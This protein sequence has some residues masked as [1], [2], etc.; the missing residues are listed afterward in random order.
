MQPTVP[1]SGFHLPTL[2]IRTKMI[3]IG[4]VTL[5]SMA[6]IAGTY[7]WQFSQINTAI[8]AEL[9][10]AMR[11]DALHNV[12][13]RANALLENIR[14]FSLN[15]TDELD[16]IVQAQ[17]D[18]LSAAATQLTAE[19]AI[20]EALG[21]LQDGVARTE[22]A[23]LEIGYDGHPGSLAEL[24]QSASDIEAA[25]DAAIKAG[26]AIDK[27]ALAFLSLRGFDREYRLTRNE[28]VISSFDTALETFKAAPLYLPKAQKQEILGL[29]DTYVASFHE[30]V[31]S[32]NAVRAALVKLDSVIGAT[33]AALDDSR[34]QG[35]A[36]AH[37]AG[38]RVAELRDGLNTA[39]VGIICISTVLAL[40]LTTAIGSTITT[41]IRRLNA[42]MRP[43]AEGRFDL[44]VPYQQ[45]RDEIGEM[46]G[47]VEVFRLNGLR[48]SEMTEAEAVQITERARER[49][50]MMQVLQRSFGEVVDAAIAGDFSQRVEASFTDNELNALAGSVNNLVATVDRGLS[51]T[52]N[53]LTALAQTDLT[54]RVEGEY[55]GAFAQL[56]DNTNAVGDRLNDIVGQLKEASAGLKVATGEILAGANDLS[57]RTT[58][59]AA[60]IEETSAAMEQLAT[61]VARNADKAKAASVSAGTAS[62]TAEEGGEVMRRANGAMEQITSSSAKIS[63]IIGLIDDIAFQ[64]NLLALNASVEAARAGEAG[65][66]FAVVAVEVRRLAQSAANAS[67][68]VKQLIEVS[69]NEV[70][71]GSQLVAEAAAKLESL[72]S[73]VRSSSEVMETIADDSHAQA[74]SIEEV[75]MAIRQ[76]DDMTQHNAALVEQ[77]NAA[78]EQT[79]AQASELDR[80]VDIFRVTGETRRRAPHVVAA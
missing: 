72:L 65:K 45:R 7:F 69:A 24:D 9:S 25:L 46:A 31:A 68:E 22:T 53:V 32:D 74:S 35:A 19:P 23:L 38:N 15:P 59:Q 33:L 10:A 5:V 71:G 2:R 51:E 34:Q 50:E 28:D 43:L 62:K 70:K 61:T 73:A 75:N 63:N 57:E 14:S 18:A 26:Y 77:T 12:G 21:D 39:I 17:T 66:G 41:Q 20:A 29:L 6:M 1:R 78:I 47:A 60:T 3:A 42:V 80:I 55:E 67:N 44:E 79:E 13:N 11:A 40:G 27:V 56:K 36:E 16:G 49:S 37:A 8:E 4:A 64:T 58:K 76:M 48:I 30:W 52:L 54:H